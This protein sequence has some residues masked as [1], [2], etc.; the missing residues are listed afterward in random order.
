MGLSGAAAIVGIGETDYVRGADRLPVELMLDGRAT[1]RSPTPGSRSRDIDGIIP[2]PGYTTTEELAANLGIDDLRFAATVHMGGASPTAALQQRGAGGRG[3]RRRE[4]ARR[5]RLERL[6]GVPAPRR[7]RRAP[8]AGFDGDARSATRSLDFYL[9]YGARAAG[10]VLRVDRDAPQAALRHARR[11]TPAT[12]A[13]ACREHAQLQRQGADARARRS[14]WTTTSRRAG[15]SEP[16]RLFDCCARDRLRGRGRRH[17]GRAGA[18]PA[19]TRR[20]SCSA[21]PRAIPYPADDIT[22]PARPVPHRP[23]ATPRRARSRWPASR[24]TTSTSS[25]STTASPTSCCCSSRRSGSA[26]AARPA[27]SC[28][29]AGIDARRRATRSTRTAACCRRATCGA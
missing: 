23:H 15:S 21:R 11:P 29:T 4:R 1:P 18:R 7:V 27:S 14:R 28:A 6:L 2:P 9:P 17:D 24:R 13:V 22:E 10:A 25:R 8:A 5:R 16:F 26:A 19:R 3:G 12:I 20:S